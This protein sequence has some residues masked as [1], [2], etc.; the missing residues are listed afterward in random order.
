MEQL[1]QVLGVQLLVPAEDDDVI[2]VDKD[3]GQ[4][5]KDVVHQP[6]ESLRGVAL[7]ESHG[8]ILKKAKRRYNGRLW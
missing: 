6:L 7:A 5:P 2:E 3:V 8:D 4:V 1:L